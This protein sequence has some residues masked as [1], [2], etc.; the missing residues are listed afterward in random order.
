M[1]TVEQ[2]ASLRDYLWLLRRRK[3]EIIIVAALTV[4]VTM[5]FTLRQTDIYQ[6]TTRV[7]VNQVQSPTAQNTALPPNLQ[8]EQQLVESPAVASIVVRK[9][10]LHQTPDS[11]LG[12]LNVAAVPN[13]NVLSIAYDSPSPRF[14]AR[15]ANGFANAYVQFRGGQSAQAYQ[16]ASLS[17]NRQ[18]LHNQRKLQTLDGRINAASSPA[19]KVALQAQRDTL[20][21]QL[22]VLQQQLSTLQ[23]NSATSQTNA[24]QVIQTASVPGSPVKPNKLRNGLIALIVG[25]VLGILLA[26][27]RHRLDIRFSTP[28]E[29]EEELRAPVLG[30]IPRVAEWRKRS[31]PEVILLTKPQSVLAEVFR[32]L[33]TNLRYAA[34]ERN[35]RL[36]LIT[37][38][39]QGEGKST[40]TANVGVALAQA[41]QRVI[42]VSADVRRP[43]LHRFFGTPN[44]GL[45]DVVAGDKTLD[46]VLYE[47][48]IP[49][50]RVI[51][52]GPIPSDPAALLGSPGMMEVFDGIRAID[53]CDFVLVDS[54]P[55]LAVADASL[56]VPYIDC[57]LMVLDA[58]VTSRSALVQGREQ[59][60]HAGARVL[61]AVF[62]DFDS[63]NVHPGDYYA[64]GYYGGAL[65]YGYAY[66]NGTEPKRRAR[67]LPFSRKN[68]HLLTEATTEADSEPV[69]VR[70][71]PE[72]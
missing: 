53:D 45:V 3:W 20:V 68:G 21:A 37:S 54:P 14:A 60:D 11:L 30:A 52:S 47:T 56:L 19:L 25:L 36:L 17:V 5:F 62:N 51:G 48:K 16:A 1:T 39:L 70:D 12:G 71:R 31:I 42:V 59:L 72:G 67:W 4:A 23:S 7:L 46:E 43:G 65:K 57:T 29:L 26:L 66:G 38:A 8:T 49:N 41:G 63:S 50:L 44:D 6:G 35:A 40:T 18:I 9:L 24:A 10:N 55:V 33:A 13:T 61:G 15:V 27:F 32:T 22:G 2:S 58:S 28:H 64:Y 69:G 34:R